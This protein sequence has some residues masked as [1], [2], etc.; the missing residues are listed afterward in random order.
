MPYLVEN[1]PLAG[2][3]MDGRAKLTEDQRDAIRGLAREGYSQRKLA[4]M[5]DVS[6]RLIQ[7]IIS[8]P[9]RKPPKKK[10]KEY[11][12]E[13]KRRHRQKKMTLYKAGKIK[14][15]NKRKRK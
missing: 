11:W 5:F 15:D 3:R 4:V 12:A 13:A 7:S 8:P 2:T 9:K 14:F 10:S 6:R 1:I